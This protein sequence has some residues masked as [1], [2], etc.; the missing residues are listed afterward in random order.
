M[1]L[2][3]EER[4]QVFAGTL[5]VLRRPSPK[6]DLEPGEVLI[7]SSTRGGKQIVDRATGATVEIKPQPRLWI[8]IKGWHLKAGDSEWETDVTIVDLRETHRVLSSGIGGHPREAGLRTRSGTR[9]VHRDGKVVTKPKTVPSVEQQK[10][11]WT[12]ETER[13]YG[14]SDELEYCE[15]T[16]TMVPAAAVDDATLKRYAD[17]AMMKNLRLQEDR[18]KREKGMRREMKLAAERRRGNGAGESAAKRRAERASRRTASTALPTTRTGHVVGT[19]YRSRYWR[20]E[21]K[22]IGEDA[23]GAVIVECVTPGLGA[24]QTVGEQWTH[25]TPLDSRDEIVVADGTIEKATVAV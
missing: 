14:G 9:V 10:E 22:V 24:H 16:G 1:K 13:G 8:T 19:T 12:P 11:H 3:K 17:Q 20:G 23:T 15:S 18:R 6:P 21:Y 25:R 2:A 7:V 4:A 5:K